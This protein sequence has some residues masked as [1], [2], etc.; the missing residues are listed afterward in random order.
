[1]MR[2]ISLI[3]AL[4]AIPLIA[5]AQTTP[6]LILPPRRADAPTGSQFYE[7]I[8]GLTDAQREQRIINEIARGNVPNFLRRLV[9][10]TTSATISGQNTTITYYVTPD[11][12]AIGSDD[13]FFRMPMGAPLAQ[14]V[15]DLVGCSLPTRK[16]VN[17]IYTAATVKLAPRPFSP[18]D[19]QINTVEVFWLSNQAIEQQRAGQPL[20]ALVGGIKKDVVITLRLAETHHSSPRVF[21]YGWHQLNGTPIQPLSAAHEATYED[22]S[23][24][25]R[26]VWNQINVNGTTRTV[27]QILADPALHVLL[28][29]EGSP[30]TTSRYP[31][32]NPYTVTLSDN[33]LRD[34]SFEQT[35]V[36]GVSP[37]WE[38]WTAPG[39]APITFGR[40][41]LNRVDGAAS[42]YFARNDTTPFDGG[43]RQRVA[44]ERGARYRL[45]GRMKRQ[46]TLAGTVMAI[47][48]DPTGAIDP[49]GTS[50]VYTSLL[51]AANDF[52]ATYTADFTATSDSVVVFGRGGHSG[53]TGGTNSYFYV[54]AMSLFLIEPAPAVTNPPAGWWIE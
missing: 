40:A 15:A 10:V 7:Q 49:L 8:R 51:G 42:Q 46:S 48:Y 44:V 33:L 4:F 26:L 21:I 12:M 6:Q 41:T 14:Q 47:G 11:Y 24:G 35:F 43:I 52:W 18:N 29:D 20:G 30:Y 38:P 36:N 31:V 54:D 22:Y 17:N 16:M 3:A 27:P 13:D 19:Y 39:S 50:V 25:V 53:T 5:G 1:M 45:A 32:P 2:E 9:P 23:H 34:G 28:N 37:A